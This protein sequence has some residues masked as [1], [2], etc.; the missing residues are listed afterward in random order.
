MSQ[1]I[2]EYRLVSNTDRRFGSERAYVPALI[3]N[4]VGDFH[5][6]LFTPKQIQEAI[7]RAR[8]NPEDSPKL[9]WWQGLFHK[10]V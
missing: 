8:A 7:D 4:E 5:P 3:E 9:S 2:V 1:S 10:L 6:A